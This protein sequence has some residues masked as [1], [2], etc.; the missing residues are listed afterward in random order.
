MNIPNSNNKQIL[1]EDPSLERLQVLETWTQHS[2]IC[3][4]FLRSYAWAL[5]TRVDCLQVFLLP[6][7]ESRSLTASF[8]IHYLLPRCKRDKSCDIIPASHKVKH[9]T[10]FDL[11]VNLTINSVSQNKVDIP[12]EMSPC[13]S[14]IGCIILVTLQQSGLFINQ[15]LAEKNKMSIKK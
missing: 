7:I 6:L 4:S 14:C 11:N 13:L 3:L 2:G 9:L 10:P 1:W 12:L 8:N 15:L 5:S